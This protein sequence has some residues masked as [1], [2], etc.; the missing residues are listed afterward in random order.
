ML[1]SIMSKFWSIIDSSLAV[2]VSMSYNITLYLT[3][4]EMINVDMLNALSH[5]S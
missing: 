5:H 4:C 2:A 3:L 1:K